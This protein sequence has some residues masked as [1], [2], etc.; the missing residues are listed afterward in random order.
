MFAER[1]DLLEFLSSFEE[2]MTFAGKL[3]RGSGGTVHLNLPVVA[4]SYCVNEVKL[5]LKHLALYP[6]A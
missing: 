3:D 1:A 5:K 2:A 6:G 4:L